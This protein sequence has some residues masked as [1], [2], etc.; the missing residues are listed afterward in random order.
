MKKNSQENEL[1]SLFKEIGEAIVQLSMV[2]HFF[3][4]TLNLIS[5]LMHLTGYDF[6][7]SVDWLFRHFFLS[8]RLKRK[9]KNQKKNIDKPF[10][11]VTIH[12]KTLYIGG[13]MVIIFFDKVL[14]ISHNLL[15]FFNKFQIH[16]VFYIKNEFIQTFL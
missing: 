16:F 2:I 8:L 9:I 10:F 11:F 15:V 6:K 7:S 12:T 5:L 13:F 14:K 3:S 1:S 4:C